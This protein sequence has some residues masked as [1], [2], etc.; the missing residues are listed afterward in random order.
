MLARL[1]TPTARL[2]GSQ[3]YQAL[4]RQGRSRPPLPS[5]RRRSSMPP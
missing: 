2:S 1:L 3:R 5:T 4:R